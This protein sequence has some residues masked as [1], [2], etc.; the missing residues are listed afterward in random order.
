VSR[1]MFGLK[2]LD[3]YRHF[4]GTLRQLPNAIVHNFLIDLAQHELDNGAGEAWARKH[5]GEID[6]LARL[7]E[8]DRAAEEY[9]R[10]RLIQRPVTFCMLAL[11]GEQPGFFDQ[12]V[13]VSGRSDLLHNNGPSCVFLASHFGPQTALPFLLASSGIR[14]TTVMAAP[15]RELVWSLLSSYC[16]NAASRIELVGVPDRTVLTKCPNALRRGDSALV[17]MEFSESDAPSKARARFFEFDVP[18]PEGPFFLAALSG[19]PVV[20]V[21]AL[22]DGDR[23]LRLIIDDPIDIPRGRREELGEIIMD[24]WE[25]LEARVRDHPAQWLGWQLVAERFT[26]RT[27]SKSCRRGAATD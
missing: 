14:L 21:R 10:Y 26:A 16:P 15:E 20:P 18:A 13:T 9:L 24:R 11:Y 12:F 25:W 6:L 3:D 23:H 27:A 7:A 1:L 2:G 22:H 17:F 19:R 4:F 5:S 8:S